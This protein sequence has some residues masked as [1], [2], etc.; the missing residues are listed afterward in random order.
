MAGDDF[1]LPFVSNQTVCALGKPPTGN[2]DSMAI[3][4]WLWRD[5]H[6]LQIY[7]HNV[8]A[9]SPSRFCM[10][11]KKTR[12]HAYLSMSLISVIDVV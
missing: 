12:K 1:N 8:S 3:V 9:I 10:L 5:S 6:Y 7:N 2:I 11:A 4:G